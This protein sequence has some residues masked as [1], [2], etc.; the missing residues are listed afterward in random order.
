MVRFGSGVEVSSSGRLGY[1]YFDQHD[2]TEEIS[3]L[4]SATACRTYQGHVSKEGYGW[5]YVGREGGRY[6]KQLAHR[7]TWEQDRGVKIPDGLVIRHLCK[8]RSCVNPEHLSLGSYSQN[9]GDSKIGK[10][11]SPKGYMRRLIYVEVCK[12]CHSRHRKIS[13]TPRRPIIAQDQRST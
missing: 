10:A 2:L 4:I 5:K 11:K 8:N 7:W 6:L 1:K 9:A 3:G 12:N 13:K